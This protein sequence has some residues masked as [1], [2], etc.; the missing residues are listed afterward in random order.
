MTIAIVPKV[1]TPKYLRGAFDSKVFALAI[2][3][4]DLG[5]NKTETGLLSVNSLGT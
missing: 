4:D 1:Q 5:L 2:L 3:F